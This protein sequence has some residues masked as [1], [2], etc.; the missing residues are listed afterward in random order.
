[1]R[2]RTEKQLAYERAAARSEPENQKRA[3]KHKPT[4]RQ[5]TVPSIPI[6]QQPSNKSPSA[7]TRQPPTMLR[8]QEET[9]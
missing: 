8:P 9:R 7:K 6:K 2:A 1:V 3:A 4:D 5:R